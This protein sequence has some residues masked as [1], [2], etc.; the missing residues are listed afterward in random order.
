MTIS[1]RVFV[2]ASLGVLAAPATGTGALRVP[3]TGD[4][5][6][7]AYVVD[8]MGNYFG[9]KGVVVSLVQGENCDA[10]L[11]FANGDGEPYP[12]HL[13][14][15]KNPKGLTGGKF[16]E[17]YQVEVEGGEWKMEPSRFWCDALDGLDRALT[18]ASSRKA[19]S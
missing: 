2:G 19:T 7:W 5:D 1:R 11:A 17:E 12:F 16:T 8:G 15:W 14:L 4:A 18:E 3:Y 9:Q 6:A 13:R 10:I